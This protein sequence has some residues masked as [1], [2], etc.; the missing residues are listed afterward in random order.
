MV[1]QSHLGEGIAFPLRLTMQGNLQLSPGDRNIEES[2]QIILRTQPGER[3][4]RPDFGCRLAELTFAPMNTQTLLMV[5]LYIQE[6]LEQWEPRI[7]ID[8]IRTDPDPMRGRVDVTIIYHA[9]ESHDRRSLVY[10]F[11]LLPPG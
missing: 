2:I 11:Y 1:E 9:K 3:V 4:Y 7:V 5:R 6:A 10:P 8:D